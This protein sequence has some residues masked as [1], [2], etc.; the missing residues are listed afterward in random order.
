VNVADEE[1]SDVERC[2]VTH[3]DFKPPF[4]EEGRELL[5]RHLGTLRNSPGLS[6]ADLL[7]QVQR[8]NHFEL[9]T[10]WESDEAYEAHHSDE[11]TIAFR[12]EVFPMLGSPWD[13]RI[14]RFLNATPA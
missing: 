11:A 12:Q 6:R 9:L 3:V 5:L 13:D 10:V 1:I 4:S 2:V 8:G 14:H 7:Q